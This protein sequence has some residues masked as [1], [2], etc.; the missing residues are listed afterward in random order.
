VAQLKFGKFINRNG[1]FL[2]PLT[3]SAHFTVNV[4]ANAARPR[5]SFQLRKTLFFVGIAQ[6]KGKSKV[7]K[8]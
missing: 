5:E 2:I 1:V 8:K 4:D 6:T 7:A 3:S